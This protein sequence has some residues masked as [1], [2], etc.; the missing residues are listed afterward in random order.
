MYA[1]E[2]A[3]PMYLSRSSLSS[4]ADSLN[5]KGDFLRKTRNRDE[6]E[7]FGW[8]HRLNGHESEQVLGDG[9]GQGS[10]ECSSPRSRRVRHSRVSNNKIRITP[11]HYSNY[12]H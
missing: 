6:V 12:S 4:A 1:G 10:L 2:I 11:S 3:S 7:V 8:H 9:K 5:R